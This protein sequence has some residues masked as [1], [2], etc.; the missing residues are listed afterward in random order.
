[1]QVGRSICLAAVMVG[2]VL[3]GARQLGAQDAPN[4]IQVVRVQVHADRVA[5]WVA[6]RKDMLAATREGEGRPFNVWQVVSGNTSEFW[7]GTPFDKFSDLEESSAMSKALG[8]AG[9]QALIARITPTVKNRELLISRLNSSLSIIPEDRKPSNYIAVTRR[10]NGAGKRR[11]INTYYAE[12][13]LPEM[14]KAGV[15]AS[16]V[17]STFSGGSPRQTSFV[18]PFEKW[19]DLDKRDTLW[20]AMGG[21]AY[22]ALMYPFWSMFDGG[23]DRVILRHRPDLSY[24]P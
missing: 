22:S 9:V 13:I 8:E 7:I 23:E 18:E 15:K 17:Y 12:K 20:G 21:E 10:L 16:Y 5:D 11:D 24:Q 6:V 19:S 14:K 4:L 1:M 3:G 2:L